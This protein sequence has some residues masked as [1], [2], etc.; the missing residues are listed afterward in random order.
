MLTYA[1]IQMNQGDSS[2]GTRWVQKYQ[3]YFDSRLLV[4]SINV[5]CTH[6]AEY[7][8][9]DNNNEMHSNE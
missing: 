3:A 7:R 2:H 9:G 8:W 4:K 5:F 6:E 1:K